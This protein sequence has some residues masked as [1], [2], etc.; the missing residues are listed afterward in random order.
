MVQQSKKKVRIS[1]FIHRLCKHLF[2]VFAK[3]ICRTKKEAIFYVCLCLIMEIGHTLYTFDIQ[4]C[5]LKIISGIRKMENGKYKM[6]NGKIQKGTRNR[7]IINKPLNILSKC[8]RLRRRRRFF[9][10]FRSSFMALEI[11]LHCKQVDLVCW[12]TKFTYKLFSLIYKT[13]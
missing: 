2:S 8:L 12:M 5:F 4:K 7:K 11:G 9:F 3:P 13:S 6:E 10:S 1:F